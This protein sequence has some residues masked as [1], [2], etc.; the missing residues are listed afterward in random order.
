MPAL[1]RALSGALSI[2]DLRALARRRLPRFVFEFIDGGAEDEVTLAR[3]R[4]GFEAIGLLPRVLVDVSGP[5]LATPI[6]GAPSAAPMV[7]SPM[8]SCA[9][10]WPDADVAIA[11]AAAAH[12]IPYTLSTMATT[13]LETLARRVPGRLWFQLYVLRDRALTASLVDRADAAGYEALVVTVDLPTGGK[14]ERDLRNGIT[15]PLRLGPAQL[16]QMLARPGWTL[17]T[18]RQGSPRYE[19]V[20][21][22]APADG[23]AGLTIAAKV[24]QMLDAAFTWDDLAR[25]RDRW[26][27]RLVVK[28]VQH[29]E[30]ADRLAAMGVDCVWVSNHGGRQ[31]DGAAA[32]VDALPAVARAV[33]G[34]AEVMIDSGIR[35]GVDVVKALALGADFV[36]FG[37][38]AL[39]GAC[40]GG[41][42]GAHRAMAILVE[43]TGRAMKLCG[44]PGTAAIDAALL[45]PR[46][47]G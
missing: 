7:V 43:E 22:L 4:A 38:P 13:S 42:R 35:R 44:M 9:L 11:R 32:A 17:R 28:G 47:A 33:R 31:L 1:D 23:E 29:P 21:D 10:G 12:G 45:G 27:R 3:N 36:A 24:G 2:A 40:A 16:L 19:N 5:S 30:D 26:P 34:R 25:L 15:V 46:A 14:R 20:R 8:G 39:F 41:E 6:L 37:R 18:L